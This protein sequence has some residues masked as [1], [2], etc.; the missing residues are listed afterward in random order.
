MNYI[1]HGE[2]YCFFC[3][4]F[5][6]YPLLQYSK[7]YCISARVTLSFFFGLIWTFCLLSLSPPLPLCLSPFIN[8]APN[9]VFRACS[10]PGMAQQDGAAKRTPAAAALHS[11]FMV[12]SV[13][14][15]NS[16]DEIQGKVDMPLDEKEARSLSP[17]S[18]SS[19]STY[20][21]GFDHIDGPIHNL[22]L[23]SSLIFLHQMYSFSVY[24]FFTCLILST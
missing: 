7:Q 20:E 17:S 1:D 15:E 22:R 14:E 6:P 23:A 21:M 2:K 11:H 9:I 24:I 3:F 18:G 12:G 13:S 8:P 19:D 10:C 4:F 16:E 5:V